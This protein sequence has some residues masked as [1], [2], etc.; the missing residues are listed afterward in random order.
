MAN[1]LN[2]FLREDLSAQAQRMRLD[3]ES[4]QAAM[5]QN[6]AAL[7]GLGQ[8]SLQG[9]LGQQGGGTYRSLPPPIASKKELTIREELQEEI[10]GW[11]EDTI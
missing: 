11:L 10:N 4:S 7:G 3:A 5:L 9:L 1:P 6:R 2:D 8:Q